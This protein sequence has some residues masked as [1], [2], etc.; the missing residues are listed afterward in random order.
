MLKKE[1][2]PTLVL[3]RNGTAISCS[4]LGVFPQRSAAAG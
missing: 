3:M 1:S 2:T 4:T